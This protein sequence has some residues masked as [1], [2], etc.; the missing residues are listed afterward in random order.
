[1]ST[2]DATGTWI[3]SSSARRATYFVCFAPA[4]LQHSLHERGEPREGKN[5]SSRK[6]FLLAVVHWTEQ[7]VAASRAAGHQTATTTNA[8][9]A[10][11]D[12]DPLRLKR[13]AQ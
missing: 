4:S 13:V 2:P 8:G 12:D 10:R 7:T 6:F 11:S 5:H 1:M 3:S 9:L